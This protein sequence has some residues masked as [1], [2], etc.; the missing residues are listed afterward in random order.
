MVVGAVA[1]WSL[2]WAVRRGRGWLSL[3]LGSVLW[4]FIVI[5]G[6]RVGMQL[7]VVVGVHVRARAVVVVDMDVGGCSACLR[8]WGVGGRCGRPCHSLCTYRGRSCSWAVVSHCWRWSLWAV[9]AVCCYVLVV[10]GGGRWRSSMV[11]VR[12]KEATSHIVTMASRLNFH[13]RSHVNDL[14]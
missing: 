14:M 13:V 11:V 5:V 3:L 2:S 10:V 8:A 4:A 9:V 7:L 1:V 6:V 12:R